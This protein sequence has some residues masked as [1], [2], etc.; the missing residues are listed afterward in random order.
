MRGRTLSN[1]A[2][3]LYLNVTA[4]VRPRKWYQMLIHDLFHSD[5]DERV[6]EVVHASR[7]S[8]KALCAEFDNPRL[9]RYLQTAVRQTI[10]LIAEGSTVRQRTKDFK[11]F[12]EVMQTAFKE[13]DHQTAHM[14]HCALT[15]PS[16]HD[17]AVPKRV[18][19]WFQ[20]IGSH[21]GAPVYEKHVH[22]WRTVRSDQILPSVIA[23]N[24]F[25][26]RRRFM[27]RMR[28]VEEVNDHMELFKY[29]EHDKTDLLPVYTRSSGHIVAKKR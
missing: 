25:R 14:L 11:F 2:R 12:A 1:E 18:V 26:R 9:S 23:F 22:F 7:N 27:G 8:T 28:E 6:E 20:N 24:T 13:A 5:F 16:L 17:I 19:P 4:P 3:L 29:L 10:Q 15:H 21:Y